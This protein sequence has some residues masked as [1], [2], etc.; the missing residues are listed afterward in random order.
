MRLAVER[1]PSLLA[2]RYLFELPA[3]KGPLVPSMED[4]PLYEGAR[5]LLRRARRLRPR[6]YV[7]KKA[8]QPYK[9]ADQIEERTPQFF[10]R[11]TRR[12]ERYADPD[13][14]EYDY[15]ET[16]DPESENVAVEILR[17]RYEPPKLHETF[18]IEHVKWLRALL[19]RLLF[20]EDWTRYFSR[21]IKE[22]IKGPIYKYDPD[23]PRDGEVA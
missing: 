19:K 16:R 22:N 12:I 15:L 9:V 18:N 7:V 3:E 4:L 21:E 8:E 10:L 2:K 20:Q 6:E 23:A 5:R 11:N 13:F 1:L 17:L 14:L